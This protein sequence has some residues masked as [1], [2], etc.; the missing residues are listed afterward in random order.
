LY[1]KN[2]LNKHIPNTIS[3]L[4]IIFSL[5]LPLVSTIRW[6][7]VCLVL[8]IEI[9]D[10]ADGYIARKY[11]LETKTGA[12]LDSIADLVF[13]V[14]LLIVILLKYD[15]IIKTNLFLLAMIVTI[16]VFSIIVSKIKYR[17]IVFIHTLANKLTGGLVLLTI[18][19]IPFGANDFLLKG[20]FV[21]AV[22][23]AIEELSIILLSKE[24]DLNQKTVF[25]L[26]KKK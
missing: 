23:A 18:L 16:K 9:S 24:I 7:F 14:I 10:V 3:I 21:I 11:H 6:A 20:V 25:D 1:L 15:W 8:I 12:R 26:K 13:Y 19:V 4:R 2:S 17:Q 5:A 22:F